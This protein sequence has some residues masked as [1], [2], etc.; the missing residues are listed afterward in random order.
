MQDFTLNKKNILRVLIYLCGLFVIAF[1]VAVAVNSNLGVS[2]VSSL[3]Y[4]LSEILPFSLGQCTTGMF[5]VYV[6]LQII[7]LRENFKKINLI[8]IIIS[9]IFGYFVD[10]ALYLLNGFAIPTYFGKLFMLLS[11][12][13]ILAFGMLLFLG[14]EIMPMPMEGLLFAILTKTDKIVFHKLKVVTDCSIVT[15]SIILSLVFRGN[16]NGLRE[17][18]IIAAIIVGKIM[19]L[20]GKFVTPKIHKYCFENKN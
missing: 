10:L 7:I 14:V 12:T 16:I 3:S 15:I 4:V 11:S 5:V 18:T 13:V 2:P 17:G 20:L 19:G 6:I 1:G 8:Q 9:F